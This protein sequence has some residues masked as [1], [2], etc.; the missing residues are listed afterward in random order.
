MAVGS[1]VVVGVAVICVISIRHGGD[2]TT[3][4]SSHNS[5]VPANAAVAAPAAVA[6]T[7]K[8]IKNDDI[9]CRRRHCR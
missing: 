5:R 9:G 2:S 8:Y 1:G 6:T 4:T 3:A 7:I